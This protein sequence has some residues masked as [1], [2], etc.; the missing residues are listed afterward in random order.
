M[1]SFGSL[2]RFALW[3]FALDIRFQ[4]SLK[5]PSVSV[6]MSMSTSGRSQSADH[7]PSNRLVR[8][9][10]CA[11]RRAPSSGG[12]AP[13][14]AS[15]HRPQAGG[16]RPGSR[17]PPAASRAPPPA[18]AAARGP[19]LR[20]RLTCLYTPHL[21]PACH[22]TRDTRRVD[23]GLFKRAVWSL[24]TGDRPPMRPLPS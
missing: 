13:P 18:P 10:T 11:V 1:V 7:R 21:P 6:S 9:P 8:V 2:A 5:C 16:S 15:R 24:V 12:P 3:L 4:S 14:A 20:E 23:C 19:T 22:A 17:Q